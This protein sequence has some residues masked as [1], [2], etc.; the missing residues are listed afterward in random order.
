METS[1]ILEF[2]D[3]EIFVTFIFNLFICKHNSGDGR[4]LLYSQM[5]AK[6]Q[7][8]LFIRLFS[9]TTMLFGKKYKQIRRTNYYERRCLLLVFLGYKPAEI[10]M[11]PF[12]AGISV[13]ITMCQHNTWVNMIYFDV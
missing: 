7:I 8:L 6:P 12:R 1:C 4:R 10:A 13:Y 11:S 9:V 2:V 3:S 5:A